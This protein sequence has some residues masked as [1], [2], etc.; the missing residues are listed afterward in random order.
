MH[1]IFCQYFRFMKSIVLSISFALIASFLVERAEAK[2]VANAYCQNCEST[3]MNSKLRLGDV[4]TIEPRIEPNQEVT[5]DSQTIKKKRYV[6]AKVLA[7]LTGAF[8]IVFVIVAR[9]GNFMR[10]M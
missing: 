5:D 3:A 10:M 8:V 9:S 4:S 7:G 2:N 6:A 1:V